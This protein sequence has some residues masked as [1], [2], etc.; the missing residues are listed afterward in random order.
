MSKEKLS[1]KQRKYI[2]DKIEML[3]ETGVED[4]ELNDILNESKYKG[5][6]AHELSDSELK[7]IHDKDEHNERKNISQ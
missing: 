5:K 4:S 6:G 2:I 1:D 7:E 3:A